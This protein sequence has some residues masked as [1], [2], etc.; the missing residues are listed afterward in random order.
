MPFT[1]DVHL[2]G[3]A[4]RRALAA[5]VRRGLTA[6]RR[7]LP[8]KYFYDAAG[9][10][11]FEAITRLPEYYLTRAEHAIL[12]AWAGELM[13][14]LAPD[15]VVELGAGSAAKL[16]LVLASRGNGRRPLRWVPVDVDADTLA[17]AAGAL[18]REHAEVAVHAV[19]GDFERHL[20]RL[21]PPAGRRLV[22]FFG[23][24][25]GNLDPPARH[26]FLAGVRRLLGA[27]G[28][29][30]LGLDLVKDRRVL[31]RAY[32]DPAGVTAAFNRN[33]LHVVNRALGADFV[34]AAY[35]HRAW[36]DAGAARI[37]MHLE[38]VAVQAVR[39]PALGLAVTL[40]PGETIWTESSYKFTPASAR[41][42]CAAAGLSVEDWRT[43][44]DG[45]FALL[46]ARPAL[47][48]AA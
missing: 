19:V 6:P 20:D 12:R 3:P 2:D 33:I 23:S 40:R 5:D 31:E 16:R 34:P 8:P 41:A 22:A 46:V 43:D 29:L 35:R 11:L 36:F 9:S 14:R 27:D 17:G 15:E 26:A 37:E 38:P 45:L 13:Q 30:L 1:L 25:I 42:M 39:V 32:D 4:R 44:P 10:A 18:A 7:F 24:T 48:L 47:A 21:P 28:R